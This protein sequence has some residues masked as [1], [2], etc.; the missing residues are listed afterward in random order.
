LFFFLPNQELPGSPPQDLR[1]PAQ[2]RSPRQT[3]PSRNPPGLTATTSAPS[4]RS[5]TSPQPQNSL[6]RAL[7]KFCT[8]Q[9]TTS[10][11]VTTTALLPS[12]SPPPRA[13]TP[14]RLQTGHEPSAQVPQLQ[15]SLRS[16]QRPS[17]PPHG[18][19]SGG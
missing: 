17:R 13:E 14:Q 10:S 6:S 5:S 16:P 4:C 19:L 8:Y 18:P 15:G 1:L 12:H 7:Q 11:P 9:T 2:P 3:Q